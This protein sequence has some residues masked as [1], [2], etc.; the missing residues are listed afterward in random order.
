MRRTHL[1]GLSLIVLT[2][3]A[4]SAA[5]STEQETTEGAKS[6]N[7]NGTYRWNLSY[8]SA[9]N[10]LAKLEFDT[11]ATGGPCRHRAKLC[12]SGQGSMHRGKGAR[13]LLL[14]RAAAISI[15]AAALT[16]E[17]KGSCCRALPT[18]K[19]AAMA[20]DSFSQR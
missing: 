5:S 13:Y 15:G 2:T 14:S 16:S 18:R 1:F 12:R 17:P 10:L 7:S 8:D 20:P 11:G 4:C 19:A 3:G 6:K 9:T